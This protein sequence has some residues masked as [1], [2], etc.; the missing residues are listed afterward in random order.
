MQYDNYQE[1]INKIVEF[2]RK[3]VSHIVMISIITG[4]IIAAIIALIVAK[5]TIYGES[6]CRPEIT[7]GEELEFSAKAFLSP[8][9]YEYSPAGKDEWSS[10]V[11]RTPG[12]YKIRAVS[13]RS[14]GGVSYSKEY[15]FKIFPKNIEISVAPNMTYGEL[16]EIIAELEYNDKIKCD[17]IIEN[18]YSLTTNASIAENSV[19]IYDENGNDMTDMYVINIMSKAFPINV[20]AR[21]ISIAIPDAR[22][23]YDGTAFAS[24]EYSIFS[25]SPADG[26][27]FYISF[28]ASL[29]NAGT[30]KNTPSVGF[31]SPEGIDTTHMYDISLSVGSLTVEKRPLSITTNSNEVVYSDTLYTDV[32]YT[33]DSSTSMVEGHTI[34]VARHTQIID[35]GTYDNELE[36]SIYD[37]NATNVTEN[38]SFNITNGT[39]KVTPAPLV[40]TTEGLNVVYDGA[41]HVNDNF[42]VSGLIN[43]HIA[44]IMSR[45]IIPVNAGSYK[46]EMTF[47]VVKGAK[48]VTENYEITYNF[49]TIEISKRPLKV[50][51][52]SKTW[53]YDGMTHSSFDI[54]IENLAPDHFAYSIYDAN[55]TDVGTVQN[56]AYIES[57]LGDPMKSYVEDLT[58]NYDIT[59]EYGTLTVTPRP[60]MVFVE[61]T[62]K[63]YDGTPLSPRV[64]AQGLVEGHDL[65][66]SYVCDS[67]PI[68]VGEYPCHINTN[69]V[70]IVDQNRKDVTHNY[71]L[72]YQSNTVS[73]THRIIRVISE[74][75]KK[76]YDGTPLTAPGCSVYM[77]ENLYY[78]LVEGHTMSAVVIGSITD[79]GTTENIW[80]YDSLKINDISGKDVT[81]NYKIENYYNGTLTVL[82]ATAIEIT[83]ADAMK[84]YDGTPLTNSNYTL[85]VVEG[86][87]I[88]GHT[89]RVNV[90]GGIVDPGSAPNTATVIVTDVQGKDV[91]RYYDI[92]INEGTLIVKENNNSEKEYGKVYSQTNRLIYFKISSYG[93][94]LNSAWQSAPK[95]TELLEDKFGY[96]YLTSFALKNADSQTEHIYV[97]DILLCMLPYYLGFGGDNAIP[98]ND[99]NLDDCEIKSYM[100]YIYDI[101]NYGSAIEELR[102]TLGDLSDE[103][104]KYREFVYDNYLFVEQSTLDYLNYIIKKQAFNKND[105]DIIEAV[106]SHIMQSAKY[107]L[108]YDVRLDNEKDVVVSFLK[109]YKEGVCRHY[110]AA[111]TMLFRALGIPARYTE[112]FAVE[113][114]ANKWTPIMSPGHAWVEVYVDGLGWI[115]V[116]VTGSDNSGEEL[117]PSEEIL[118]IRPEYISKEYDG[119]PLR[120]NKLDMTEMLLELIGK[121]YTYDVTFAGEQTEIGE[122]TSSI[123]EFKL[124]DPNKKDVTDQFNI[125]YSTGTIQIT[126]KQLKIGLYQLHKYYDGKELKFGNFDYVILDKPDDLIVSVKLNISLTE[127]GSIT[128]SMLNENIDSYVAYSVERVING[129]R[130]D[131]TEEFTVVM[132]S[133]TDSE[134]FVPLRVEK[135]KI[136]LT[137]GSVSSEY[138]GG[139]LEN[140]SVFIS[141][142]TLA[143]GHTIK[144]TAIGRLTLPGSVPNTI[145]VSSVVITDAEG[146]VVTQNYDIKY[147]NGTLTFEEES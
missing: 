33:L 111:A 140:N 99:V 52:P 82:P 67:T 59:Y 63:I 57:I 70:I 124:Y 114:E 122:S 79:I 56:I 145:D 12:N 119:T 89:I 28:F 44:G 84:Y 40:I 42:S 86:N 53:Q 95:Y 50:I 132:T 118:E 115:Q 133:I 6:A 112:G 75:A 21:R 58:P 123:V 34:S 93:D 22:K 116:E 10:S 2:M 13:N 85:E 90:S 43:G 26:D 17:L 131:V 103:E 110:A 7:Y 108:D 74:S 66:S 96:S 29:T 36:F 143:T 51:T 87:V 78:T 101:E 62:S 104:E 128:M 144:A 37:K 9:S 126:Q 65:G 31:T 83:T 137:S 14:F 32:S 73:I 11:P 5:G 3:V 15:E 91:T 1:K 61:K 39:I 117:P 47:Y 68:D 134:F 130:I 72:S 23:V 41:A 55:I 102:N 71:T 136:E 98:Q 64:L 35:C 105:P 146:N 107:N 77:A 113:A 69:F 138:T 8:V 141:K 142:G 121:G 81:H 38:Y 48:S 18:K 46:N 125:M 16:P 49:G 94:F 80:V 109:D 27:N 30:V 4:A 139:V 127:A 45:E 135:R 97:S 54:T 19:R 76:R 24:S 147:V 100:A 106:A 88:E 20:S 60:A 25:G 92:K 120:A 129:D